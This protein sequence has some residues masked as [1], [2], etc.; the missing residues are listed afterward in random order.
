M[1]KRLVAATTGSKIT[2]CTPP[3][4]LTNVIHNG[5]KYA[6]PIAGSVID[7]GIQESRGESIG[8]TLIKTGGHVGA[9]TMV[10]LF[11]FLALE[12]QLV[13]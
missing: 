13:L 7:L 3:R 9:G 1:D 4:L 6:M 5:A 2:F 10:W 8:D 11:L 12:Q